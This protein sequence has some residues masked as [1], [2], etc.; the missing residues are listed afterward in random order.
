MNPISKSIFFAVV[1]GVD[2]TVTCKIT[3]EMGLKDA[4]KLDTD[5]KMMFCIVG[6]YLASQNPDLNATAQPV[7]DESKVGFI[8]CSDLSMTPGAKYAEVHRT[9]KANS[10]FWSSRFR[11]SRHTLTFAELPERAADAAH[12]SVGW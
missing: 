10:P 2:S 4:D 7:A 3:P 9:R 1:A 5:I 11:K 6:N 12:R 8:L